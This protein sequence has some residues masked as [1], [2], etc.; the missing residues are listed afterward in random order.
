MIDLHI[1]TMYSDG[2]DT[3]KD[4]L[5]KASNLDL[6]AISITDH[7]SVKFYLEMENN[8]DLKSI[9]KGKII[10]GC[11]FTTTYKKNLIEILGYNFDYKKIDEYLSKYYSLEGI[12]RYGNRRTRKRQ[13]WRMCFITTS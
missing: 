6:D 5:K 2:I 1:H 4:V 11:E 13:F 12:R 9:F 7:N 10:T 8:S 3:T